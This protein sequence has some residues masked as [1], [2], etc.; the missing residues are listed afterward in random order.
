M[1]LKASDVEVQS[2]ELDPD[3]ELLL[4]DGAPDV[5][6]KMKKAFCQPGNAD[7]CPPIKLVEEAVLEHG[8]EKRL[9]VPRKEE[10]GGEVHY[11]DGAALR[12]A[13]A[14]GELHPG[15]LKPAVRD[16]V[17][18]VLQRV[19]DAVKASAELAKALKEVE[20]AAKKKAAKK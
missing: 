19:R 15:D 18:K 14:S 20:K 5:Q 12:A 9:V 8:S 4:F 7:D 10:D 2:L 11:T 3:A 16:A 6:R 1:R 13:F 17:D